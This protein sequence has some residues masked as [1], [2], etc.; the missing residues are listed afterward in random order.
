MRRRIAD[1]TDVGGADRS[2]LVVL[3][4]LNFV[5]E[6]DRIAFSTLTPEIR[7]AFSLSDQEI[8]AVGSV[9]ALFFLLAA[10]PVGYLAD[11][12]SRL[13][14]AKVAAVT[15]GLMMI[16]TGAAWAFPILFAARFFAGLAKSSNEIVHTGLLIDY[17]EPKVLPRVFQFHRL[18]NPLSAVASLIAGGIALTLGWRWAFLLLALP[19]FAVVLRMTGLQ[20]PDR[21]ATVDAAAA[22]AA[23]SADRL[24]YRKA[25]RR[26]LRI[27][28][29]RRI[30]AGFFVFGV[31]IVAFVQMLSLFFEDVYGYGPLAR[32]FVA[33]LFGVGEVVGLFVAGHIGTRYTKSNDFAGL[34]R[35]GGAALSVFA[36]G[37]L[38][39]GIAP[40]AALSTAFAVVAGAGVGAI[41]PAL[42]TIMGRVL[43]ARIRAQGHSFTLVAIAFGALLA[44]PIAGI[45]ERGDY[46]T[47]FVILFGALALA[48]PIVYSA[49]RFLDDDIAA[50]DAALLAGV[51]D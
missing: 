14:M 34:M 8:V 13:R 47:A 1:L 19:T 31:G 22:R 50:A 29:M 36:L 18:A 33:F 38:G 17:Y 40:W 48:V 12:Y 32:G 51:V 42:S 37:V 21:G 20:D 5:D 15:W 35:I 23:A 11:R 46:R 25:T 16:A 4:L 45:G 26:L 41:S 3:F 27:A 43:P 7:D 24:P 2:P 10:I 39:L 30:W 44:I 9:S 28:S 49:R 6:F